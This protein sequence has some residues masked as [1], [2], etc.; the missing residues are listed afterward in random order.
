MIEAWLSARDA[1]TVRAAWTAL[2][3]RRH[4]LGSHPLRKLTLHGA[5]R[6]AE[7][8]LGERP[9]WILDHMRLQHPDFQDGGVVEACYFDDGWNSH[10]RCHTTWDIWERR[11]GGRGLQLARIGAGSVPG[12]GQPAGSS[13]TFVRVFDGDRA[14]SIPIDTNHV[15]TIGDVDLGPLDLLDFWEYFYIEPAKNQLETLR[16]IIAQLA[17]EIDA[18]YCTSPLWPSVRAGATTFG[19]GERSIAF[20]E[21]PHQTTGTVHGLPWGHSLVVHIGITSQSYVRGQLPDADIERV[22]ARVR[23]ISIPQAG[24]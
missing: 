11:D 15:S 20:Q 21:E 19:D 18:H 2:A 24:T 8:M 17:G 4:E 1:A 16:G 9:D 5:A 6:L 13:I 3:P 22:L 10:N 7:S 12:E 23:A 14:A